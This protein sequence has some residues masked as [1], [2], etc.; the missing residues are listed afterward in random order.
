MF[1]SYVSITSRRHKNATYLIADNRIAEQ[2]GWDREMLAIEL[3]ELIDLLPIEGFDVSVTGFDTSEID[4]LLADM[5]ISKNEPQEA[6]PLPPRNAVSKPGDLW[7]L[8]KHRLLCGDAQQANQF[9]R[10]MNG[11]SAAAVFCDPPYNLRVS[12]IGGRGRN[13]HPEFAFGSGEMQ[14]QQFQTIPFQNTCQRYRRL[15]RRCDPFRLHGLAS[16]C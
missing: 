6:I 1:L 15:G 9:S 7:Q 16:C 14:P 2:A 11:A 5:A 10:L 12:T 3:G 8:G 13:K 4:L